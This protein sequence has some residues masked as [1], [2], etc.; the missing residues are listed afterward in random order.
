MYH[1][2]DTFCESVIHMAM[3]VWWFQLGHIAIHK[4]LSHPYHFSLH[5]QVHGFWWPGDTKSQDIN[6]H[7]IDLDWPEYSG[8]NINVMY[9]DY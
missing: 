2:E 5:N 6:S 7:A 9:I 1:I 4:I 3:N 8:F